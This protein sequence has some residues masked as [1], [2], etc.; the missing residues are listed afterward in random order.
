VPQNLLS[1]ISLFV[2]SKIGF[3]LLVNIFL[4]VLGILLEPPPALL[5]A[6]PLLLPL[7]VQYG[8][9]P[10]HL[11]LIMTCNLAIGLFTPPVGGTLFVAAKIARVSMGGISRQLIPHFV[12]CITVLLLVTYV[13]VL[14]MGLVWLLR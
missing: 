6:V 9:D 5:I 1:V 13:P 3:L 4:L 12:V 8:V 10:V 2:S 14:P 11:G 7:A